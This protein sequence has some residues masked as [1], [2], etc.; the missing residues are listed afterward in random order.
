[1]FT[2]LLKCGGVIVHFLLRNGKKQAHSAHHTAKPAKATHKS[3]G[4]ELVEPHPLLRLPSKQ[5]S[6]HHTLLGIYC[7]LRLSRHLYSTQLTH[8][9]HFQ[10]V[11]QVSD[12][13][14]HLSR[15]SRAC[16]WRERLYVRGS[17]YVL[18]MFGYSLFTR[19]IYAKER[20]MEAYLFRWKA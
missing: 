8:R 7:A 6:L 19:T 15:G 1:M 12:S 18:G 9:R 11:V 17:A 10:L 5:V 3:T 14:V 16:A 4:N 2:G 13:I 20:M